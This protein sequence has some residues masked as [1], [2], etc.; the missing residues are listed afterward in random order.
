MARRGLTLAYPAYLGKSCRR[1]S[2]LG[3]LLLACR[4]SSARSNDL[5]K[6]AIA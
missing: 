5:C 4:S 2:L 1:I 3:N 6:D